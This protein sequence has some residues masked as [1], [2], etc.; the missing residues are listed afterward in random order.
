MEN[1][2]AFPPTQGTTETHTEQITVKS[3]FENWK[4]KCIIKTQKKLFQIKKFKFYARTQQNWLAAVVGKRHW[5]QNRNLQRRENHV[6]IISKQPN[7][8]ERL[9]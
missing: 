8:N 4:Q 1:Q 6:I 7:G 9:W 5:G 3:D 2:T